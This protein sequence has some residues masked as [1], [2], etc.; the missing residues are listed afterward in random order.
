M[1][2]RDQINNFLTKL[3]QRLK[4]SRYFKVFTTV[5]KHH[6]ESKTHGQL[7]LAFYFIICSVAFAYL[8][9][10]VMY[11]LSQDMTV[12]LVI[13]HLFRSWRTPVTDNIMLYITLM[14]DKSVVIPSVIV[15]AIMLAWKKRW[16]TA[17]H[18]WF[19]WSSPRAA[20]LALKE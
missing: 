13:F 2:V 10:Y 11:H 16:N 6:N 17:A 14:G 9:L 18:A 12:N 7:T 4:R 1:L 5:L 15:L 3:W 20:S 19:Y 8:A